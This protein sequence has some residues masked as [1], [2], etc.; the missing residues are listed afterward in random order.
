MILRKHLILLLLLFFGVAGSQASIYR[1]Y[2][3]EDGLSHNS[4]WAVM[5]DRQGFMWFG[6]N[7]GLNRFDGVNF[8]VFRHRSD[9]PTSIGNNFIHCLLESDGGTFLVGT[10]EGLYRYNRQLETFT[11]VVLTTRQQEEDKVSVHCI[12]EDGQGNFWVGC[13]GDGI[14]LLDRHLHVK[15]HYDA[16]SLSTPYVNAVCCDLGGNVW[17]G[18]EG[19]GLLRLDPRSGKVAAS[20]VPVTTVSS[21]FCDKHN[22]L[23]VGTNAQGLYRYIPRSHQ[24]ERIEN[25][26]PT[27]LNNVKSIFAYGPQ[28]IMM[29]CE[30]G[31]VRINIETLEVA[32]LGD[33][34]DYD[35]L[36]DRSIF[37]ICKDKEGGL[38]LGKYFTG[39]SY[40]S[41]YTNRFTY[42]AA[43]IGGHQQASTV[44][45][46]NED[47]SG[48]I[49]L[50]TRD[51][52]LLSYDAANGSVL[53][54]EFPHQHTQTTAVAGDKLWVSIYNR[55]VV[56]YDP[57]THRALASY[58]TQEGLASNVCTAIHIS[59]DG[60]VWFGTNNGVSRL[61]DGAMT[62]IKS[63]LKHPVKAICED[64]EGRLWIACHKYGL[65]RLDSDGKSRDY[66]HHT[67][68]AT[69][70]MSNNVNTVFHDTKG[71]IWVGTEGSGLGLLN[72]RSGRISRIF[73]EQEGMPSNIIYSL[74]EDHDGHLWASTGGGLVRISQSDQSI[75]T[76]RD[77]EEQL[78][79]N[80]SHNSV[81]LSHHGTLFY[82]GSNG[83]LSF[84][85]HTATTG[86]S[87]P[88]VIL[89][90][91]HIDGHEQ[92]PGADG[93]PL[94]QAIG[95]TRHIEF[96]ASQNRFS[97]DVACL[98]FL[99]PDQNEIYY[100]LDGFDHD[101]KRMSARQPRISY[102]NIPAGHYTLYVKATSNGG[103]TFSD[104]VELSI[105]IHRPF[106][107]SNLMLFVY[108]AL[109]VGI[110][111]YAKARYRRRLV[112]ANEKKMFH[113][114][115]EKEK[116]LYN[117]KISFFTNIAHEIRTPLSLISA[118]LESIIASGEGSDRTQGNLIIIRNNVKRL[119][120][121]INQLLDFRKVEEQQ[122][123]LYRQEGDIVASVNE[124][125]QRYS[126]YCR[127]HHI[128][129]VIERPADGSLMRCSYDPDALE[130]ML[131][132]LLSNAIKFTSKSIIVG[133]T[134]V[135]DKSAAD[136]ATGG[137]VQITVTD[138]GPGIKAEEQHRIFESFYQIDDSGQHHGTG[139]GLP[140]ARRLAQMH[141]GEL[142]IT[143]DY[144][145][146][147]T[148][149]LTLPMADGHS[150]EMT[151]DASTMVA[152]DNA[153]MLQHSNL[154]SLLIVEDNDELRHF[155]ANEF[156]TEYNVVEAA[157]GIEALQCLEHHAI[158]TI[159]SDIMM[160]EMD[161]IEF[162]RAV[163]LNAAYSHLPFIML[164]AKTDVATKVEG[165]NIGADA[166]IEKPFAVEQLRAQLRSI[167][168]SQERIRQLI[169]EHPLEYYRHAPKEETHDKETA[170]FIDSL[171]AYILENFTRKD[172][173]IDTLARQFYMSRSNFHKK[174]KLI[175]GKTPNDYIRIIR[176]NR[177]LELLATG[178]YQ[179]SE[180]CYMVGFNTPSYF[181]KCFNEHFGKL[182]NEYLKS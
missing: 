66:V 79:F 41:P 19:H 35:N 81:L 27:V 111:L 11:H 152:A 129:L 94:E 173:T 29:S 99:T 159:V 22:N 97:L 92:R 63:T 72:P 93:S 61:R 181:A 150:A 141:G 175:T 2:Y 171:N 180:V 12:V 128:N 23:W 176:L 48:H 51:N 15:H 25:T 7:D 16:R 90:A 38:W 163:R 112:A 100:R 116:E 120:E 71:N 44:L 52:G 68:D 77:I 13:Y 17:V 28:E 56:L 144:G 57:R 114:T 154:P 39:V 137:R 43:S 14:F 105:T 60:T 102:M 8:R 5:Q 174:L 143:S 157:N 4:V 85:P 177:S 131:G 160:P 59:A 118:P 170:E 132:N 96:K 155:V 147:S 46:V 37:S 113:F 49:W 36:S 117:Q 156:A 10:K 42:S 142:T 148:F 20:E 82:G 130:K 31:A 162:C 125:C 45:G 24:A 167:R 134:S 182:P 165:L 54:I 98:S 62:T 21:L 32:R 75:H 3:V 115:M 69:S 145:H 30:S 33:G 121:L 76:F 58:T 18:T 139:L 88:K 166:Y 95:M 64:Y 140:L 34:S 146:G 110:F 103:R 78:H 135:D 127:L 67:G 161:G 101:W 84:D 122:M 151:E 74:R 124:I 91:L 123:R 70:L 158:D 106:L 133:I 73:S 178:K 169:A 107:L 108:A 83:L 80:Y 65:V 104:P 136:D 1:N 149:T 50:A 168:D 9:N 55:G 119:L 47:A 86:S 164:S 89:T 6:T 109:V 153:D 87:C 138:D 40:W 53:A 172:F 26:P 179:I 126:E